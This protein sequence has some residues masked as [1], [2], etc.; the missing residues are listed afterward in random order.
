MADI[1][2]GSYGS[3]PYYFAEYRGEL[4]FRAEAQDGVELYKTDG[5]MVS[6]VADINPGPEDSWPEKFTEAGG[7]LFFIALG[8]D[9]RS[10]YKFDGTTTSFIVEIG[11]AGTDELIEFGGELFFTAED[12]NYFGSELFKTDGASVTAFHINPC[13]ECSGPMELI[14]YGGHMFFHAEGPDGRELYKVSIIPEPGTA[15][16]LSSVLFVGFPMLTRGTP[17]L[18]SR[19]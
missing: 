10:L 1:N 14:Q 7:E 9:G 18:W 8:P 12:Y 4:F 2:P 11:I 5:T 3:Y 16:L 6:I 19:S 15:T 13:P 17:R